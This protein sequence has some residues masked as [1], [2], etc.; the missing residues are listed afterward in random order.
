[1]YDHKK[2]TAEMIAVMQA[3]VDG[4][5]IEV[6]HGGGPFRV[7][8]GDPC[9]TWSSYE[10]RIA[11]SPDSINWDHVAPEWKWMARDASGEVYFFENEPES[12]GNDSAIWSSSGEHLEARGFASYACGTVDWKQSLVRR[13]E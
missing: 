2:R 1:M 4:K 3:Y 5:A 13:P 7:F 10:Y 12:G 8:N 6:S 11:T 9:W